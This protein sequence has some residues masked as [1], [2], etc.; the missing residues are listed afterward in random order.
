MDT[1]SDGGEL[2]VQCRTRQSASQGIGAYLAARARAPALWPLFVGGLVT[3][4]A[5]LRRHGVGRR[6]RV[7]VL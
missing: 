4:Q 2:R 7:T 6:H 3:G 1:S 5:A